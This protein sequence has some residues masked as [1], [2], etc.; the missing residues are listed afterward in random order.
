MRCSFFKIKV[1]QFFRVTK[2]FNAA[3]TKDPSLLSPAG[4]E[5]ATKPS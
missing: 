3:K 4:F 1:S 2:S 5:P